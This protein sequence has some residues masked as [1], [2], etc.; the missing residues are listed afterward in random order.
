MALASMSKETLE[1]E[2]SY[3]QCILEYVYLRARFLYRELECE[4]ERVC[5]RNYKFTSIVTS[6][7]KCAS[8]Y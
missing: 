4:Y 5:D 2:A 6:A 7:G 8:L 3:S 1:H